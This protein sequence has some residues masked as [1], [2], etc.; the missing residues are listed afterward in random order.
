MS[1]RRSPYRVKAVNTIRLEDFERGLE[2]RKA[3]LGYT[4]RDFVLP[5]SGETRTP[6]KRS[7]LARLFAILTSEGRVSRFSAK[8]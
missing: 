1:D 4:G 2:Q 5:N 3:A 8:F 6:E 7:L